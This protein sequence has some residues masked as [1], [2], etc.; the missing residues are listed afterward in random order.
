M[1]AGDGTGDAAV[2]YY[3]VFGSRKSPIWPGGS[4]LVW[5]EPLGVYAAH[6]PTEAC[7][8]AAHDSE[9]MGTFFAIEGFPW[10]LELMNVNA[11]Q[12]GQRD[13]VDDRMHDILD[14]L[15]SRG[16]LAPGSD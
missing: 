13:S 10:G 15:A 1:A 7:K 14:R 8:A 11:K 2:H 12:L 9:A 6:D 3:M 4:K 16:E 5:S